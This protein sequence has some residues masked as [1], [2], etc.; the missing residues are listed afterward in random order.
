[1]RDIQTKED[2]AE[3]VASFYGDLMKDELLSDF[4]T[5]VVRLDLEVHLPVITN[6]WASVLLHD[7]SYRGNVMVKHIELHAKKPI[8][9]QHFDRWLN[10]W[11]KH[12][13]RAHKGP[14]ADEAI[15]RARLM[16]DL[17]KHKVAQS[18]KSGFIQ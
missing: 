13:E 5:R 15:K 7:M 8:E 17:M 9:D 14:I 4:F 18:G 10:T 16:T 6:F 2:I 11:I 1:M 3:I 12:V